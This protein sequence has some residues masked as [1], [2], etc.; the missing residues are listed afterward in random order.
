LDLEQLLEDVRSVDLPPAT[1]R[2][3]KPLFAGKWSGATTRH[4]PTSLAMAMMDQGWVKETLEFTNRFEDVFAQ[5]S[6]YHILLYGLAQQHTR[7]EQHRI[8][9]ALYSR[10]VEAKPD[11]ASGHFNLGVTFRLLR[12]FESAVMHLSLAA[13]SAPN[14]HPTWLELGK[15]LSR[16]GRIDEA[17]AQL[18]RALELEPDDAPTHFE[19]AM[20]CAIC[21]EIKTGIEHLKQAATLQGE[22][23]AD[24]RYRLQFRAGAQQIGLPK[25]RKQ[26]ID[27]EPQEA[28]LEE[29]ISD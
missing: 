9:A 5:D 25:L 11:F 21:G 22:P 14:D 28:L 24:E 17:K 3:L 8:A 23:Y 1:R 26:G 4:R 29:L 13:E 7:A 19:V 6:H 2:R 12:D 16:L 18:A 10:A 15:I 20:N 27:V